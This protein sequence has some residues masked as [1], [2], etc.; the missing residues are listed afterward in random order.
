MSRNSPLDPVRRR[1][2]FLLLASLVALLA[3]INAFARL[4][5]ETVTE[6]DESLYATSAAEMVRSGN[7][8]A[9]T[10]NGQL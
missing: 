5:S 3:C 6:W 7:W 10:F 8:I 2:P 1:P 4:G 9:T